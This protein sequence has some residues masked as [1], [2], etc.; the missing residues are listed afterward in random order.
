MTVS[1]S[2]VTPIPVDASEEIKLWLM[3]LADEVDA[4]L[5]NADREIITSIT[6]NEDRDLGEIQ[7]KLSLSISATVRGAADDKPRRRTRKSDDD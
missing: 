4:E 2:S 5:P 6:V 7:L 3:Q 1:L